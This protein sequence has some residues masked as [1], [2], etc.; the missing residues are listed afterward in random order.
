MNDSIVERMKRIKELYPPERLAK[1]KERIRR[2]WYGEPVL[3]RAPFMCYPPSTDYY[4]FKPREE[5]L[6]SLLDDYIY[7]GAVDDDFIPVLYVGCHQGGR[8]AYFGAKTIEVYN[9]EGALLDTHV[10][11]L[12]KT[13]EDI[14]LLPRPS[15][16]EGSIPHRWLADEVWFIEQT[17]CGIPVSRVETEA[18]YEI[19]AQLMGY[20]LLITAAYEDPKRYD[21]VME[22]A[23][24][25]YTM[26]YEKQRELCGEL[27]IPY[28]MG[29]YN[30][31]P[32]EVTISGSMDGMAML[33]KDF[34]EE[35]VLPSVRRV[36][37]RYGRPVST[38][39]CGWYPQLIPTICDAGCFNGL[40]ATQMTLQQLADAGLN[41]NIVATVTVWP[42]DVEKTRDLAVKND[43]RVFMNF[44]G[45][46][47]YKTP[48][49]W[50][51]EDVLE[52]RK[53]SDYI[54]DVLQY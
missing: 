1:S 52:I 38:H 36:A 44:N 28:S 12:V 21:K 3:D 34:F 25:A 31:A 4:A 8:A 42:D 51:R 20:E 22:L 6:G 54:Q 17:G 37:D 19:A 9:S 11:R 7:H 35:F 2:L 14:D 10:E 48:A 32:P 39:S 53:K 24:D 47:P 33:S 15:V 41:R 13:I 26:F 30:W 27:L 18:P 40:F 23:F 50:T 43:L 29:A 45:M 16:I 46:W 49:Q 5:K